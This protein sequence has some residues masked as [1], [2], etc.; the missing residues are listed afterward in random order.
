M[1]LGEHRGMLLQIFL[2]GEISTISTAC[3]ATSYQLCLAIIY[4]KEW[5]RIN[6]GKFEATK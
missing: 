5:V 2:T 1:V 6:C 3:H 4:H